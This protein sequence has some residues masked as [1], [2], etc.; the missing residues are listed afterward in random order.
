VPRVRFPVFAALIVV[1]LCGASRQAFGAEPTDADSRAAESLFQD[2]LKL[3]QAKRYSEA[4]PKFLA[5]YNIWPG[6]GT[7]LNL[8]DCFEQEGKT[9]SA[10]QRFREAAVLS[11]KLGKAEREK[12]AQRR[13]AKLEPRL[14]RLTI[15]FARTP[16]TAGSS[17]GPTP[18]RP[19]SDLEV[20]LNGT[21][22]EQSQLGTAIPVDPGDYTVVATAPG[23]KTFEATLT[24][25]EST[26]APQIEIPTLEPATRKRMEALTQPVTAR[27]STQRIVGY[28]ALGVGAV[29][30]GIATYF[31][32][33]TFAKW[34]EY[35]AHCN[36]ATCRD[37]RGIELYDEARQSQTISNIAI[38][39]SSVCLAGGAILLLTA[40]SRS[41]APAASASSLGDSQPHGSLAIAFGPGAVSLSGTF[42]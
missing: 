32:M 7:L 15:G 25:S 11:K 1:A 14:I 37:T 6:L 16:S 18:S 3:A 10:W 9:A 34:R 40:P 27:G 19:P 39:A 17:A 36:G 31:A 33:T 26:L 29:G 2:A 28:S 20:R 8:A 5:S 24:A 12:L 38:I 22:I 41:A 21:V 30:A 23:H 4:C 13:T 42:Q 35:N